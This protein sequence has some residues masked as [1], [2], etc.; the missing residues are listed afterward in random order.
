MKKIIIVFEEIDTTRP[1]WVP[2]FGD[3]LAFEHTEKEEIFL[4]TNI[5]G[6]TLFSDLNQVSEQEIPDE[7][8]FTIKQFVVNSQVSE[9]S[10]KGNHTVI[11]YENGITI[12]S[13]TEKEEE[14]WEF[15]GIR[16]PK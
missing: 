6:L 9:I 14:I 11:T 7:D 13:W 15:L 12:T 8:N 4:E 16:K 5:K 2:F 1:Q 3:V 10:K